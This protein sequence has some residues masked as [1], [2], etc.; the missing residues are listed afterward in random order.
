MSKS[1]KKQTDR[2]KDACRQERIRSDR[3]LAKQLL[4]NQEYDEVQDLEDEPALAEDKAS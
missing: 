4:R 3:H 1:N 2:L